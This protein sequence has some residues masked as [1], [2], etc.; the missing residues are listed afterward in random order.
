VTHEILAPDAKKRV[1]IPNICEPVGIRYVD[2]FAMLR[3][4]RVRFT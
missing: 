2:T 3:E 1:P 4:L